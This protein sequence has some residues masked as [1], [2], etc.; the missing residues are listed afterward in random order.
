MA[1]SLSALLD[2]VRG[3][4]DVLP[5]LAALETALRQRGLASLDEAPVQGLSKICSQ[6]A[7]LPMPADDRPLQNLQLALLDA[8]DRRSRSRPAPMP[9]VDDSNLEVAEIS[10]SAFMAIFNSQ[11]DTEPMHLPA[12][13]RPPGGSR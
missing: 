3:S 5:H 13:D 2:R 9:Y 11:Q 12:G 6:L 7:S 1:D 10:H 8:L 4:R